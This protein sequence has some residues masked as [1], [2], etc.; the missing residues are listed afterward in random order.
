MRTPLEQLYTREAIQRQ[1]LDICQERRAIAERGCA[2]ALDCLQITQRKIA[3][4]EAAS[5]PVATLIEDY[6]EMV[7]SLDDAYEFEGII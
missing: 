4:L 5:T 6:E 7:A 2:Q 1:A 3:E